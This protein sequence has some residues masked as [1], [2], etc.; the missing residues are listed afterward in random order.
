MCCAILRAR[1]HVPRRLRRPSSSPSAPCLVSLRASAAI[2]GV[3][4]SPACTPRPAPNTSLIASSLF[5]LTHAHVAFA[6][7]TA[8][9]CS[10]VT[11]DERECSRQ[12]AEAPHKPQGMGSRGCICEWLRRRATSTIAIAAQ[13]RRRIAHTNAPGLR[14]WV[15]LT[16]PSGARGHVPLTRDPSAR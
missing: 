11:R 8:T 7:A 15:A 2:A 10:K 4:T 3:S 1:C 13:P 5:P 16:S 12:E 6:I 9:A 14:L